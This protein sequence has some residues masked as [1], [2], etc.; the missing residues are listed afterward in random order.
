MSVTSTTFAGPRG[1]AALPTETLACVI[2]GSGFSGIAMAIRCKQAG[3]GPI[4]IVEKGDDVGGTWHDN[5]YPGA[6]CDIPSH[7]Y[8]LSFVPKPDW[9][10]LY[11]RQ[12]EIEA[13]LR[14]TADTFGLRDSLILDTAVVAATWNETRS[15]WSVET[16]RGPVEA[17][18]I[19]SGMGALHYPS[20]PKL[21][22]METFAGPAFHSAQWDSTC[23]LAGKRIGV[24]GTG[25]SAIQFVPQIAPNA[26]H[27]TLFQRTPPWVTPKND[28]PMSGRETALFRRFP[29]L[30][31]LFRQKLFWMHE[32]RALLG[33]TKVSAL[34]G[35]AE[36]IALKHLAKA[37]PDGAL[38]KKL[39]PTYRLGCKRVLISDDYYPAL[40]RPNVSVETD[41]IARVEAGA[42][43]TTSG[44]RHA[45][46]VIIYGTGFD[47]SGAFTNLTITGRNGVTLADAWRDGMGAFQGISV[48][49]FPNCFLLMGPNTGLGHNSMITMIEAQVNHTLECLVAM[50]DGG[51][52]TL[53]VRP[54]AQARFL[55]DVRATMADSIWTKGGCTSWY[56]D[57]HGR[58]TTLWPKSVVAYRRGAEHADLADY[59]AS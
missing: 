26:A 28:R 49:G 36:K 38:R 18:A 54:D 33:F 2:I 50:R 10:R 46:D 9:S 39:T 25:A 5:R 4:L 6:A 32:L 47:V 17:R 19:V 56:L 1:L 31:R 59:R 57:E 35:A 55:A 30:R 22:G 34:T 11:P 48:T 24:V 41:A 42:I 21:P 20:I 13:Y 53:D 29:A 12:P 37:V 23:D 58:N 3:I 7:L 8:S 44:T 51:L 27:L 40:T 52:K 16:S 45:L 43:V 15:S 14:E